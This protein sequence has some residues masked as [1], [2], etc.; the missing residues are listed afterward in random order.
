MGKETLVLKIYI[1]LGSATLVKNKSDHL[2]VAKKILLDKL[3]EKER[4]SALQEA[5]LLKS[6]RHPN[7]VGYID[8]FI[9]EGTLIIVMEYCEGSVYIMKFL[10]EGSV[11]SHKAS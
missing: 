11:L 8:S 9:C 6:L 7:I 10:R 3:G 5:D 4:Q 1:L 2:F